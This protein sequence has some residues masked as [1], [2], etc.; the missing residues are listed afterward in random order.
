MSDTSIG[1]PADR[2]ARPAAGRPASTPW[3]QVQSES[4]VTLGSAIAGAIQ[5]PPPTSLSLSP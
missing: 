3:P 4:P 5:V 1:V 2:R